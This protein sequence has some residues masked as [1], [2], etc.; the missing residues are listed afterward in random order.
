M[1]IQV[2]L[3]VASSNLSESIW[4][5]FRRKLKSC[6]EIALMLNLSSH[7]TS[8]VAEQFLIKISCSPFVTKD[9]LFSKIVPSSSLNGKVAVPQLLEC[10]KLLNSNYNGIFRKQGYNRAKVHLQ[11]G[12]VKL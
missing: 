1:G 4:N 8:A 5:F 2:D 7:T 10:N 11:T 12:L 6:I 3:E 9:T